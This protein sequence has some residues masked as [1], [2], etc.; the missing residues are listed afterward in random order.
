MTLGAIHESR[1]IISE[2]SVSQ[3]CPVLLLACLLTARR[4]RSKGSDGYFKHKTLTGPG[5]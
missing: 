4:L 5:W 2:G 1:R 3:I